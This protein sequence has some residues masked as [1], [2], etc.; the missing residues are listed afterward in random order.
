M[1]IGILA[2]GHAP[3]ALQ[4]EFGDYP[5][6]FQAMLA[7]RGYDWRVYDSPSLEFPERPEECDGYIVTGASAGVYDPLPWI[8][9][10]QD[11]LVA[12]KGR[13][14]LVGV[15][16]GHQIMAQAFG[17]VV[18]KSPKGRATGLHRYGVEHRAAMMDPD[19]T[20]ALAASHQDQVVELP[21]HAT[22]AAGNDFCPFGMLTYDDQPA[23][24]LQLHPEFDPGFAVAL[25]EGRMEE[26]LAESTAREAIASLGAPNDNDRV[27]GWIAGFF[28][29]R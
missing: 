24:S 6:M 23:V 17:G 19:P 1:R 27:A 11:F 20:F 15:C 5:G 29:G 14:K 9:P 25:I 12:A 26:G 4:G 13:A 18:I 28:E 22:V 2:A 3:L 21:P 8:A 16:F 7:G 10:L